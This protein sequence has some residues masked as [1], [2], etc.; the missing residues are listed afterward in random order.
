MFTRRLQRNKPFSLNKTVA[1]GRSE[2]STTTPSNQDSREND[3]DNIGISVSSTGTPCEDM[4]TELSVDYVRS[5]I[6]ICLIFDWLSNI[7]CLI[8]AYPE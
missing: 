1:A 5:D 4:I 8:K 7:L 3:S 6:Q 2:T